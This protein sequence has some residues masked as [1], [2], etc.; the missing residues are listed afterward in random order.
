[1]S[2]SYVLNDL[3]LLKNEA[4]STAEFCETQQLSL[5]QTIALERLLIYLE[6]E[7]V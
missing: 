4:L 2:F 3:A 5:S 1:L 6:E 7:D